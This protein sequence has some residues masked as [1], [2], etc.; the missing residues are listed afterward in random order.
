MLAKA[1]SPSTQF[2]ALGSAGRDR[3]KAN[4]LASLIGPLTAR[5]FASAGIAA[6][7]F[8]GGLG[9]LIAVTAN[10]YAG[11]PTVRVK[12]DDHSAEAAKRG[13]GAF[14]TDGLSPAGFVAGDAQAPQTT[15]VDGQA[16]VTLPQGAS[17]GAAGA[18]KGVGALP[19]KPGISLPRAPLLGLIEQSPSG[20]LPTV[21]PDGRSPQVAYARPFV[22]NGKPKVALVLG[23]LGLNAVATRA[24]IERLP[25][26][27]TLSFVAY[28]DN[29]QNWVDLARANG[30]E[31][32]IE[33][34][35][36]PLDVANNDPGPY[37]L[38][39]SATPT[40]TI[41]RM[42]WIL[43]RATGYFG[44]TNYL[45]GRFLTSDQPMTA[46][47]TVMRQRGL[48]FIDDGAASHRTVPGLSRA[49][50]DA[51]VDA[52]LSA[53]GIQ[54]SLLGLEANAKRTGASMGSAFAYPLTLEMVSRWAQGVAAR[55]SQL[56]PVSAVTVR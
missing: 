17:L 44:V 32:L 43:S 37:A 4:I 31:V 18:E 13:P 12:I 55:G 45:G 39:A 49:T 20:P 14:T 38:M 41:K 33:A 21:A 34:P 51:V 50:A 23:G 15:T 11:A 10:P 56:A 6:L 53:P 5:P 9:V 47:L 27:I 7:V 8:F 25:P 28:S 35:M 52:D 19:D 30:H 2:G 54:K 3:T 42:E 36:E 24:A 16:V 48:A 29:L 26:E 22:S 40:E 1:S 46:F